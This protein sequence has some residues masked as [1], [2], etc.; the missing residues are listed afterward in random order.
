MNQR[1]KNT[2]VSI[3][4]EGVS[5]YEEGGADD[6]SL[7]FNIREYPEVSTA[8]LG[9]IMIENSELDVATHNLSK[10]MPLKHSKLLLYL[11]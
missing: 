6:F 9:Q 2:L 8:L 1:S 3:P 11:S 10:K 7:I 5:V 4:E